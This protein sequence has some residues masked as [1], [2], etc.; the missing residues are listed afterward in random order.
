LERA[1]E[2][3]EET[4][5]GQ[6]KWPLFL[7]EPPTEPEV[8]ELENLRRHMEEKLMGSFSIDAATIWKTAPAT[9]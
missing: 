9:K 7:T 1:D 2:T 8:I 6:P 3:Y 4:L 5:W